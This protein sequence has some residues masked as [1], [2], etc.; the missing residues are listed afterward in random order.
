[1]RVYFGQAAEAA[2][3]PYLL[4]NDAG[5]GSTNDTPR[6][7][8]DLI[9]QVKAVSDD[10]AEALLLSESVRGVLHNGSITLASPW[11]LLDIQHEAPFYFVENDERR[12]YYHAGGTYRVRGTV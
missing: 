3:F 11:K 1:M 7:A 9:L 2:D 4:M 6:D 12:Q 8:F 5:G 10:G